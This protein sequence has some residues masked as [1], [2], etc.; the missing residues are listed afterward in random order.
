L[1]ADYPTFDG[2]HK[3]NTDARALSVGFAQWKYEEEYGTAGA[4]ETGKGLITY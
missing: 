3:N 1:F 2:L 4:L